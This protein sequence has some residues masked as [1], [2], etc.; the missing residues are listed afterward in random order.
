[1]TKVSYTDLNRGTKLGWEK[2]CT[3]ALSEVEVALASL[4]EPLR[5]RVEKLPVIF[6]RQPNEGSQANGIEVDTPGFSLA[7]SR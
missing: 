4:V 1:M 3:V 6:E 2:L 7:R 5:T